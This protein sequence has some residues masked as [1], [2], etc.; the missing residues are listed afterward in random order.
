MNTSLNTQLLGTADLQ[1]Y[2]KQI[3]RKKEYNRS[4]YQSKVKPKRE[5]DRQELEIFRERCAK[6]EAYISQLENDQ[7]KES[8]IISELKSQNQKLMSENLD[9]SQQF[10]KLNNDNM[11]LR[12]MLDAC[13]KKTYE[14]MM[15]KADYL[16]PNIQNLTLNS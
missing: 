8:I 14:L 16:L 12:Q 9:L 15:Q 13:R 6:L 4:Y 7:P 1:K 2:I 10:I 11:N 5:T 3:E